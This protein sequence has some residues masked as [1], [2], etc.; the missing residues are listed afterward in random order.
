MI[1][2]DQARIIVN[3]KEQPQKSTFVFHKESDDWKIYSFDVKREKTNEPKDT[4]ERK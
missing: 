3:W 4:T 2:G 1:E